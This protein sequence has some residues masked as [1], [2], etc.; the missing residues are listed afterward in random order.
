MTTA[1]LPRMWK[2]AGLAA[3]GLLAAAA[4]AF[5]GRRD[6]PMPQRPG[7]GHRRRPR[8]RSA[9][10]ARGA[11]RRRDACGVGEDQMVPDATFTSYYGRPVVKAAPWNTTSPAY[12]FVGG[13]AAGSSLL[14]A[15]ADLT[16]RPVLRRTG[17]IA[18]RRG[19]QRQLAR[20]GPRPRPAGTLRQHAA[21]GQADLADVGGHLDPHRVRSG[22]RIWPARPRWRTL[23]PGGL[24]ALGRLLGW[25]ARPAGLAAAAVAPAVASYTAVLLT[26]TATPAWHDAHRE[27][28]FVFVGSAAAASGGLGMLLAPLGR[29]RARPAAGGRAARWSSWPPST[30][31]SAR[32]ACR[33]RRCTPVR[34]A[35]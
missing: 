5:L 30:G 14:G 26:D 15:G 21:G 16:G 27:L 2:H 18:A 8:R 31:W 28:P 23:L 22:R 19:D 9:A 13:L 34:R 1:D 24:G 33:P 6:E 7:L 17:R 25:T 32:W 10:A 4:A 12:L 29:G 20:S 11:A 3:L 35:G